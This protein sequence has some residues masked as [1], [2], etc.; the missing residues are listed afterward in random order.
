MPTL[1]VYQAFNLRSPAVIADDGAQK[2][3]EAE[4]AN[5]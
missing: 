4:I 1:A 5:M 3:I 2:A